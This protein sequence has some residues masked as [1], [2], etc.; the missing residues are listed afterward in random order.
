MDEDINLPSDMFQLVTLAISEP[1][2][3]ADISTEVL[4]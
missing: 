2:M 3:T 1:A 4:D